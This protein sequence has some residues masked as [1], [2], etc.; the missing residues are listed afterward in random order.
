MP[1]SK[2]SHYAQL[3]QLKMLAAQLIILQ[4]ARAT[5]GSFCRW[6]SMINFKSFVRF[7]S[8]KKKKKK[9]KDSFVSCEK[10]NKGIRLEEFTR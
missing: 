10:L 7:S 4:T 6:S 9:M 2:C 8:S 1:M 5:R 3:A